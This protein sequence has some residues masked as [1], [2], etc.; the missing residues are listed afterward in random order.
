MDANQHPKDGVNLGSGEK[1]KSRQTERPDTERQRKKEEPWVLR[2]GVKRQWL[3]VT[4]W[5]DEEEFL[6]YF[7]PW[8]QRNKPSKSYITIQIK[9]K[10]IVYII[11]MKNRTTIRVH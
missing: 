8:G 6:A 7:H 10:I 9:P 5:N 1:E 11:S 4:E 3:H 2:R